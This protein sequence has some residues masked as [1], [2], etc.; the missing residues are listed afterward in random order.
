MEGD[1]ASIGTPFHRQLRQI[2]VPE[3]FRGNDDLPAANP[4]IAKTETSFW[5]NM[6]KEDYYAVQEL[7]VE[8]QPKSNSD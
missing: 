4:A 2:H 8:S 7:L 6:M 1:A 3:E 5:A